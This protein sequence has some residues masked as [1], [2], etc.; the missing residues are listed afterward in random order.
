MEPERM[1]TKFSEH[2]MVPSQVP[3]IG[4]CFSWFTV[5]AAE[6]WFGLSLLFSNSSHLNR[7]C[8]LCWFILKVYNFFYFY[9]NLQLKNCFDSQKICV[10]FQTMLKHETIKNFKFGLDMFCL[11]GSVYLWGS[12]ECVVCIFNGPTDSCLW[13]HRLQLLILFWEAMDCFMNRI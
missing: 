3:D 11:T 8:A 10:I 9:R 4:H 5:C 1:E 2:H 13:I 6:F 7:I 12:S